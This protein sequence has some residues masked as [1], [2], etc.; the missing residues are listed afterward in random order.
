MRLEKIFNRLLR[1]VLPAGVEFNRQQSHAV[2]ASY[3]GWTLDAFDFFLLV[4][5][6]KDVAHEFNTDVKTVAWAVTLTLA[7]RPV[8]V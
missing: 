6:M 8:G 7:L 4:F 3:L 2:L 5:V 1:P